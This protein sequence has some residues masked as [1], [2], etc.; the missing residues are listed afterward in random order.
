LDPDEGRAEIG[1]LVEEEEQGRQ[2]LDE[3]GLVIGVGR[4]RELR[5]AVERIDRADRDIEAGAP[6]RQHEI[7]LV[8]G[9]QA[10]GQAHR[11]LGA[12]GVVVLGDLDR[13]PFAELLD[14][15]AALLVDVVHPELVAGQ[16]RDGGALGVHARER[17]GVAD[18]NALG[19]IGRGGGRGGECG[20]K[21]DRRRGTEML[22]L[23]CHASSSPGSFRIFSP[24]PC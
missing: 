5:I 14:H 7:H 21:P 4:H 24:E 17:D 9:H 13:N 6:G 11:G 15:D 10:L 16:R 8:L 20:D 22:H 2:R 19:R 18:S 23:P 3:I 1:R 12:A